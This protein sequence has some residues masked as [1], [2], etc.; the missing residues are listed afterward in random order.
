MLG[1]LKMLPG[2][3]PAKWNFLTEWIKSKPAPKVKMLLP[4]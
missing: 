1:T 2:S 4:P 3:R